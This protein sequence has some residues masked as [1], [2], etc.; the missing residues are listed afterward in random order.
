MRPSQVL[1]PDVQAERD[2]FEQWLEG[3]DMSRVKA[4]DESGIV[5]GMRLAYG[6]AKRGER[7]VC[8]APL[9]KGRRVSLI[10]WL[11]SDGS[12]CVAYQVGTIKRYQF[13]GFVL[14]HLLPT[15]KRGDIV[16]WDNARIHEAADVVDQIEARGAEVKALPR[17]S[18]EYNPIEM[19]WSKLKHWIKKAKV[20]TADALE[21]ALESSVERVVATDAQG[22]FEHCGFRH[23][24]V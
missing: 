15:L 18:P 19:L 12:G 5:Q 8:H 20:D 10:G 24:P 7:L 6:Y 2:E 9:R 22:W 4:L 16:L 1:R 11:G 13:R 23:Q 21:K 17:Y 14:K 3:V